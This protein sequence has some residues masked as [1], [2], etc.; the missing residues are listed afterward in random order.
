MH[1]I[2]TLESSYGFQHVLAIAILSVRPSVCLSVTQVDQSKMVQAKIT[3][4]LPS[5]TWKT[6]VL[7][8]IKLL[9]KCEGGP[10]RMKVLN[11]RGGWGR[12]AI[13]S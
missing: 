10:P 13:F 12:V 2:F 11:E 7:G 5:A 4:S 8:T 1:T 3:K 6:L 9:R